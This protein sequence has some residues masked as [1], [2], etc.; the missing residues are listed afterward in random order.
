MPRALNLLRAALH[1]RRSAFDEGLRAAGFDTV[2]ALDRP[3]HGDLLLIWN[4]YGGFAEIADRFEA[5]GATVLIAENGY[6]GKGWRG[7]EW[8][9]LA[10]GHHAGA[11]AW[12]VGGPERWDGWGVDL[13]PFRAGGDETVIFG[14]RGIGEPGVRSPDRWAEAVRGRIG[15][16]IRPHPGTGPEG[17]PLAVDLAR[18]RECVTWHSGAALLA[19]LMGVPVW[20]A[21]PQWIGAGAA[22]SLAEYGRAEPRRDEAA[23]LAMFRRLAWSMWTLDEIRT[24]EP[25]ARLMEVECATT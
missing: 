24:G 3:R 19:L 11:G 6:L 22:R 16:R 21:F 1:Y 17:V 10:R 23:R 18:A 25:I 4:R 13:A 9:S 2:G 20:Y 15:G 5:A 7:G 14:Q 8:F 12:P